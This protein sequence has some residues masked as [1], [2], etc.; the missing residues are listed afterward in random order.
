VALLVIVAGMLNFGGWVFVYCLN[1]YMGSV[2]ME[3]ISFLVVL[4][5]MTRRYSHPILYLFTC[6]DRWLPLLLFLSYFALLLCLRLMF[7]D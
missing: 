6:S 7:V 5:A 2:E 1:F 3:L 4:A